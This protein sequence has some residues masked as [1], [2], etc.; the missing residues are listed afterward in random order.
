[1]FHLNMGQ[2]RKGGEGRNEQVTVFDFGTVCDGFGLR[3]GRRSRGG[4]VL[5][6]AS[7]W[8]YRKLSGGFFGQNEVSTADLVASI[9]KSA[10]AWGV[11]DGN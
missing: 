5:L 3:A 8:F 2:I 11:S 10:Y 9:A 4:V 1:M 6:G 7:E